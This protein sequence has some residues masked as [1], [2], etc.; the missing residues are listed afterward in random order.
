MKKQI[1]SFG[2]IFIMVFAV[3]SFSQSVGAEEVLRAVTAWPEEITD[4]DGFFALQEKVNEMG[5]GVIRIEYVGGPEV[6]PTMEQINAVQNGVIDIVWLSAGYTVSN[7]PAA[8]AIKLSRYTPQEARENGVYDLWEE[9]YNKQAN[10]HLIG[11]GMTGV[12]FHIYTVEEIRSIGDFKGKSIRV[13]PSYKDFIKEMGGSPIT[14]SPG[15]VYTALERGIADGY[16]WIE[17]GI[18]DWGWDELTNYV[19]DPGFYQVDTLGL[20]NLDRWNSLSDESKEII[21]KAAMEMEKEMVGHYEELYE[22][23]RQKLKE[24]GIEVVKFEGEEAEK[25]VDMAYKAV[26]NEVLRTAPEYGEKVEELLFK[27]YE[28]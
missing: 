16:G 5:E 15:D 3:V 9:I 7:V 10:A 11:K 18:G 25:Y 8:N 20:M 17:H 6:F 13:T 12:E 21:N 22:T 14:M 27:K 23:D 26:L 4:N 24:K 2:L 1:I 28:E 19:I